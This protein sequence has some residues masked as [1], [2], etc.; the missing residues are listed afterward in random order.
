VLFRSEEMAAQM[1]RESVKWSRVIR[2]S[3]AK[4]D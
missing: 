3:G 4:A 2:E 1:K